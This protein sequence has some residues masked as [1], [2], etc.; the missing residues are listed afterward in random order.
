MSEAAAL[1]ERI[2][3]PAAHLDAATHRLLID[4]RAFDQSGEWYKQGARSC[5]LW[6]SWRVGWGPG[7]AREH[8]RVAQALA[9]LPKIDLAMTIYSAGT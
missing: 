5:A 1:G 6:L 2:A 8:V 3:E 4:L 9:S 7:T